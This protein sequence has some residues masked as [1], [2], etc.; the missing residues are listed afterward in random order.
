[1][2]QVLKV[3]FV[4]DDPLMRGA[5]VR[6]FGAEGISVE[7]FDSASDLLENGDLRRPAVLVLDVMMPRMSGLALQAVLSERGVT[8]PIIFLTGSTHI[9]TVVAAM[10]GGA[11]DYLQKP[12]DKTAL[13]ACVRQAFAKRGDCI[14]QVPP[15]LISEHAR[16]LSSLTARE[17]AIHY[18]M[19]SGKSSKTIAR[20]LGGSFRTVEHHRARVMDKMGVPSLAALVRGTFALA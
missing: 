12:F 17:P 8:L 13:V 18:L 3:L 20:E 9:P 1:M 15:R 5:M 4:D 7:V 16:R 6:V 11:I 2:D 10:R 19:I 14:A